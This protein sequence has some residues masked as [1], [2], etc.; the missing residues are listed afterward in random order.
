VSIYIPKAEKASILESAYLDSERLGFG[1][2]L[3]SDGWIVTTSRVVSEDIKKVVVFDFEGKSYTAETFLHDTATPLIFFKILG[4]KLPV[5]PFGESEKIMPGTELITYDNFASLARIQLKAINFVD[6]AEVKALVSQ[7]EFISQL[8]LLNIASQT[9]PDGVPIMTKNGEWIGV[10]SSSNVSSAVT[11]VP[12]QYFKD[13]LN[14]VLKSGEIRRPFLG[15]QYIDLSQIRLDD[16]AIERLKLPSDLRGGALIYRNDKQGYLG[17]L[18]KSPAF[19]AKL[20]PNDIIFKVNDE[21]LDNDTSLSVSI[22]EY[23]AGDGLTL[24]ILRSGVE[25]TVR[26][27]LGTV[28]EEQSSAGEKTSQQ[29]KK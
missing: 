2:I 13:I 18:P 22:S 3:T 15:V 21:L 27:N 23:Q 28:P 17:I 20:L 6:S 4:S 10:I 11:A 16:E 19:A 9:V 1:V 25:R 8:F 24:I 26:V 14:E 12:L 29:K 7:S 5:L